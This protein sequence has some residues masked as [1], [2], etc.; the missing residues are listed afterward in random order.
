MLRA[1]VVGTGFIGVVHVDALRR[2]GVEVTGVVGSTPERASVKGIAPVYDSLEAMLADERVDVVHITSPN[3][4]HHPQVAQ[5]LAAGK[6]VV[7][8]KPLAVTS[9]ESAELVELAEQS[10]LVNCTNFN[11][12]FYPVVLEARERVRAGELGEVW[13]VHGGYLQDWLAQPTDWNWR[14]EPEKAGELRAVGDIGS[15]WMDLTQFVTGRRIVEVFADLAT[16]IPTRNRP[17]G[18]VETFASGDDV[19]REEVDVRTEDLAHILLRFDNGAC[20]SLVVSQVSNGRK[21]SLRFE[22]DGSEGALAWDAE[23]HEEL[24]LGHRDRPNETLLRNAALMH[25]AAAA[26]THL[27]VAHA[28][29]Y[30][31]TFRELY[32]AVYA[33]VDRGGPSDKP[34]YPTFH[35]GHVENVLCDAVA[36]SNRERRWVEVPYHV[37][38]LGLLTAPFPRRSLDRVAAWASSEG[39]EMLEVACWPAAGGERRRYAGTSHIDVTRVDPDKV[40]GTLE[41]HGLEISSLAY[42][43]NNLHPDRGER[44]A[45]NAHLR[46]VID[47]AAKLEVPIVGTFVGRDQTKN[48]PDNFREFRKVWPRLVDHAES[49]GVKIAIENCP[50]IFSLRRVAGRHEPRLDAGGLGRDVLDRR[51]PELRAQPRPVAPRVADDRRRAGRPRLRVEDLPRP[52]EGPRDRSRR[53]L[54]PRHALARDGLAGPAATRPRRGALGPLR[55]RAL[56]RG[57]RLRGLDRAR[58]PVVR[59]QRGARQARLPDRARHAAAAAPLKGAGV[60]LQPDLVLGLQR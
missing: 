42:Y 2:L 44:R 36:L 31:D 49:R 41:K 17:T 19:D 22:V 56:P 25:S 35:D 38:K 12:R 33:D 54:P 40:R 28:E 11:I 24:W 51:Q 9:D 32:R 58:G 8:E 57:L 23:R 43:P 3:H 50:M 10:G 15:H 39:F 29:G 48:V 47:A 1:A 14:L 21:N 26:H 4:L 30:A 55:R 20:G 6:H 45:A 60:R 46:K 37:M 27:P 59:G 18:E 16:A 34:A 5:A 7:C 13:N 52:R 53:A